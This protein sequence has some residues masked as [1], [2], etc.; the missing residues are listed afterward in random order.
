MST[1]PLLRKA[2]RTLNDMLKLDSDAIEKLCGVRIVANKSACTY[3]PTHAATRNDGCAIRMLGV[4]E[5]VNAICATDTCYVVA[6]KDRSGVICGFAISAPESKA[7]Y[8]PA[9]DM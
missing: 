3:Y 1:P 7:K 9:Y 2:V 5:I 8:V 6:L 4:V